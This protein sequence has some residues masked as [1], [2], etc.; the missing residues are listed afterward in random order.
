MTKIWLNN[1]IK[2]V[3]RMQKKNTPGKKLYDDEEAIVL[4]IRNFIIYCE[5]FQVEINLN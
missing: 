1:E 4:K 3:K 2:S 5:S